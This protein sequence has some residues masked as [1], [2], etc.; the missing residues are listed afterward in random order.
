MAQ[1]QDQRNHGEMAEFEAASWARQAF[2]ATA[3]RA[4]VE[5]RHSYAIRD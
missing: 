3:W 1:D 5:A 2:D 4:A